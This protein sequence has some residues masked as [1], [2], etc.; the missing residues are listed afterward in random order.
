MLL[1]ATV[2]AGINSTALLEAS[3]AG[4]PMVVP[5][6]T[7]L[8]NEKYIDRLWFHE[9]YDIFQTTE[10]IEAF[11][12]AVEHY[13]DNPT[14]PEELMRRREEL[15]STWVSSIEKD[16]VERHA[17]KLRE[18]ISSGADLS[19]AALDALEATPADP[20]S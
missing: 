1:D 7:C 19:A 13:L 20:A 15:F 11:V 17:V 16:A 6:F 10:N 9:H 12:A 8:H 5:N 3:V 18:F 14:M 2:V 4:K